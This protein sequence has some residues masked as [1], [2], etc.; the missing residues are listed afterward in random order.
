[1][2][3]DEAMNIEK[4]D[5]ALAAYSAVLSL[6]P[7]SPNPVLT[8]WVSAMLIRGQAHEALDA[9]AKVCIAW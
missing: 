8:G 6:G 3:G 7:P 4:H 5:E 2:I 9:A 1:M